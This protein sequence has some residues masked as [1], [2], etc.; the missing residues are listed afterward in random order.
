MN[1]A[2]V[3]DP[4]P[5]P[6]L[7]PDEVRLEMLD[8]RT[9]EGLAWLDALM[10]IE[11]ASYSHPWTRGNFLDSVHSGYR[12]QLL[13]HGEH[14]LGYFVAMKGYDEVHL[15]NITVSPHYRAQ[16]WTPVMLDTLVLWS[17][18][19]RAQALWLEVRRSNERA[20]AVYEQYGFTVVG[21]R[22]RYYPLS[23]TQRED[24]IVMSLPLTS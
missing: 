20:R 6:R 4:L 14:L 3:S 7:D 12:V 21:E 16:G 19:Q 24:A 18:L 23:W 9:P 17:R 8:V 15:L 22:K 1:A 2:V 5:L 10:L 11:K 13:V